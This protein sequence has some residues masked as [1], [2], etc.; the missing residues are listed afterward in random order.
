MVWMCSSSGH[1]SL[2]CE[3]LDVDVGALADE[4]L[5]APGIPS[6]SCS[7]QARLSSFISL[8]HLIFGF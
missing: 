8:V 4:L 3:V 6:D 5:D 7:V 1:E 2:T